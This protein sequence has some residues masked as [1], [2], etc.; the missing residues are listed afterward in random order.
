MLQAV[1]SMP[2]ELAMGSELSRMQFHA[3]A[4]EAVRRIQED[5]VRIGKLEEKLRGMSLSPK[6]DAALL[7]VD[8]FEDSPRAGLELDMLDVLSKKFKAGQGVV[9]LNSTLSDVSLLA[10]I[11]QAASFG[12]PFTVMP[13]LTDDAEVKNL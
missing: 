5:A 4:Q 11:K 6:T 3:R 1:L 8:K 9:A 10:V 2:L 13:E 12:V 7:S